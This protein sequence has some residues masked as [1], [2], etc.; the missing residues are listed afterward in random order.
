MSKLGLRGSHY[1]I[2]CPSCGDSDNPNHGHLGI[3][4]ETGLYN[5][6][7]CGY[8]G[9]A[10]LNFLLSQNVPVN[11]FQLKVEKD[12]NDQ[13]IDELYPF[14]Y[15]ERATNL[16]V[17][18]AV[19]KNKNWD[20]F[21]MYRQTGLELGYHLRTNKPDKSSHTSTTRIK[22]ISYSYAPLPLLSSLERPITLVEGP[23]DCVLTD[24][25]CVFG[26]ITRGSINLVKSHFVRIRPDGDVWKDYNKSRAMIYTLK[27]FLESPHITFLGVDYIK[28]GL[29]ID[30]VQDYDEDVK[31][32]NRDQTIIFIKRL[33]KRLQ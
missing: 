31:R 21:P 18:W 23:Y 24:D 7:K 10:D 3:E 6:L 19:W 15:S 12:Y 33:E 8:G 22:G 4:L 9:K 13:Y 2:R 5:C 32:F 16:P 26:S 20:Y 1:Y 25:V 14:Q 29:D 28:H 27:I 30:E 11:T 17:H